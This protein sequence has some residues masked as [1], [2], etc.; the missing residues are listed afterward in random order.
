MLDGPH[1]FLIR[2]NTAI[3]P[4]AGLGR[5]GLVDRGIDAVHGEFEAA[6]CALGFLPDVRI[7]SVPPYMF[8]D[9]ST[10]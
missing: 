9:H 2:R 3:A 1:W 4:S 6:I 8:T 5:K 10:G 7:A